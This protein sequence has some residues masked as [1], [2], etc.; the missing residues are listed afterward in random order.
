MPTKGGGRKSARA[1][2]SSF[3]SSGPPVIPAKIF[4][5]IMSYISKLKLVAKKD[6]VNLVCRYWSLKREARRGAP[7]LKRIHLEVSSRALCLAYFGGCPG[8]DF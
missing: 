3:N 2:K 7:L 6:V 5:R 1:Y 8:I 4:D